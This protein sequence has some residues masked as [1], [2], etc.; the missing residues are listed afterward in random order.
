MH[1][2]K[3][4]KIVEYSIIS[5][6]NATKQKTWILAPHKA[7]AVGQLTTHHESY[8]SQKNLTYR[9]QLEK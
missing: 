1:K 2:K 6:N 4:R 5:N 9:T 3:R 7:A 8:P